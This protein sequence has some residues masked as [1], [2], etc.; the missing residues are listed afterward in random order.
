[1]YKLLK[2]IKKRI[3]KYSQH[4]KSIYYW[5]LMEQ[6]IQL[7]NRIVDSEFIVEK[8]NGDMIDRVLALNIMGG[9]FEGLR[10]GQTI[11]YDEYKDNNLQ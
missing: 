4:K 8:I 1:M 7:L 2:E 5:I 6:F 9:T 11:V 10:K 3:F